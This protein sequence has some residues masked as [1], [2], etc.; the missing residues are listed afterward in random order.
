MAD[1]NAP[2]DVLREMRE[3]VFK[4]R[5]PSDEVANLLQAIEDWA[6]RLEAV[7]G[8]AVA[9]PLT[10]LVDWRHR[11]R[12]IVRDGHRCDAT[13]FA[14]AIWQGANALISNAHPDALPDGS[15]SKSTMK[16]LEAVAGEPLTVDM[17]PVAFRVRGERSREWSYQD[18]PTTIGSVEVEGLFSAE[19]IAA[20]QRRCA[21]LADLVEEQKHTIGALTMGCKHLG[22]TTPILRKLGELENRAESAERTLAE[23]R[24]RCAE[25]EMM[26]AQTTASN[27]SHRCRRCRLNYTPVAGQSEDCPACGFDGIGDPTPTQDGAA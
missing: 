18:T 4:T 14:D 23:V 24:E 25:L 20:L 27:N 15:L 19:Q 16:R 7:G 12:L 9:V 5:C 2:G 10:K 22:G 6:A 3:V 17:Q 26:L 11:A 21:F 1:N 8:E 13:T